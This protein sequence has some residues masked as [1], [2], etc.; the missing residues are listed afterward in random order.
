MSQEILS[1]IIQDL[2]SFKKDMQRRKGAE[3]MAQLAQYL[4]G[5]HKTSVQSLAPH[6]R[7]G[8]PR[9][10]DVDTG[11]LEVQG[12]FPYISIHGQIK[13][14]LDYTVIERAYWFFFFLKKG[15]MSLSVGIHPFIPSIQGVRSH[16]Y[17]HNQLKP[18]WLT[19]DLLE[20]LNPKQTIDL[21]IRV[22]V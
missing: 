5:L 17:I 6:K 11:K 13:M 8:G 15:Q 7:Y 22:Q 12:P 1:S 16:L 18:A 4:P 20:K 10:W 9:T 14:S 2:A 19:G 3:H 21:N